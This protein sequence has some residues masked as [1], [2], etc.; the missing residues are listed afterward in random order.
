MGAAGLNPRSPR[1]KKPRKEKAMSDA[2]CEHNWQWRV[3][4][5]VC[6]LCGVDQH[7]AFMQTDHPTSSEDFARDQLM[8]AAAPAMF[9]ALEH[10]RTSL[11]HAIDI[12]KRNVSR[13]ALGINSDGDPDVPGGV[14]SWPLLDEYLHY[15]NESMTKSAA[16]LSQA[17][18]QPSDE[19]EG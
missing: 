4:G 13:D 10:A 15:M 1:Q 8:R 14:R 18:P 6:T 16:A 3:T 5:S 7:F 11:G 9:E 19:G 12:I 2:T 17:Q